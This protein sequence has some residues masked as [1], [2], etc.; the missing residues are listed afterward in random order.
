M[1]AGTSFGSGPGAA[2]ERPRYP[3]SASRSSTSRRIQSTKSRAQPPV[4]KWKARFSACATCTI[5]RQ[6]LDS[7]LP[8]RL[9]RVEHVLADA[10]ERTALADHAEYLS[11]SDLLGGV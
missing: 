1:P 9:H 6:L 3:R 11:S 2:T 7:D 10:P 4:G 8:Q 5:N